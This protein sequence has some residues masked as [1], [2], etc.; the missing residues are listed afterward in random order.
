MYCSVCIQA[1]YIPS[2]RFLNPPEWLLKA[3]RV[4][5]P[6]AVFFNKPVAVSVIIASYHSGHDYLRQ[7]KQL[8]RTNLDPVIKVQSAGN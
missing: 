2:A 3:L 6:P 1:R 8:Q 4:R 5:D 7:R